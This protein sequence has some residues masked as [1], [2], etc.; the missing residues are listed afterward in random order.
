MQTGL[1]LFVYSWWV[2]PGPSFLAFQTVSS[3]VGGYSLY[4]I[5]AVSSGEG[6]Y[7]LYIIQTVSSGVGGYSLYIIQTVSSGVGGYSFYIIQTVSSGVG[8]YSLYIITH[9]TIIMQKCFGRLFGGTVEN[10]G[11]LLPVLLKTSGHPLISS[12]PS[13]SAEFRTFSRNSINNVYLTES[14]QKVGTH[15]HAVMSGQYNSGIKDSLK[16]THFNCV[17]L[18]K[19]VFLASKVNKQDSLG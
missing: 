8:G 2:E 6:G 9:L 10:L 17:Y 15:G 13:F 4:I 16:D 3:G 11:V 7:S 12:A 14:L 1:L 18:L 5:Q 19:P